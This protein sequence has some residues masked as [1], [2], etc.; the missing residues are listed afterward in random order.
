MIACRDRRAAS[1]FPPAW[2]RRGVRRGGPRRWAAGLRRP[3]WA[4]LP[5]VARA[6]PRPLAL[7]V[8]P[9]LVGRLPRA[10]VLP[11]RLR[12]PRGPHLLRSARGVVADDGLSGAALDHLSP[13]RRDHLLAPGADPP[14]P[15][16]GAAGGLRDPDAFPRGAEG[17]G[18]RAPGGGGGAWGERGPG[19]PALSLLS[20]LPLLVA[21][22]AL[23]ALVI[24]P[25]GFRWLPADRLLDSVKLALVLGGGTSI[26]WALWLALRHSAHRAQAAGLAAT[27]GLLALG[28]VG[29]GEP[30]L[31]LW[32]R[33]NDWPKLEETARGLRLP[34]VLSQP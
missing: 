6:D 8:E 32:P 21:V 30:T 4:D 33:P 16:A 31:T 14:Q 3:S 34:Q 26:A 2:L 15:L 12:V 10:P 7:G 11:S 20:L 5:P 17:R 25:L 19:R 29:G 23:D 1:L 27:A 9:Q 13:P 24:E 28:I 18:R 22:T